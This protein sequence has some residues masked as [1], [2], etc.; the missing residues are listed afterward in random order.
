MLDEEKRISPGAGE[1][2]RAL[3]RAAAALPDPHSLEAALEATVSL[4]RDLG[5]ADVRLAHVYLWGDTT[6]ESDLRG[7]AP[8]PGL[9]AIL[10]AQPPS[11]PLPAPLLAEAAGR[12][13]PL[14]WAGDADVTLPGPWLLL[15]L[16]AGPAAGVLALSLAQPVSPTG[17]QAYE[18]LAR[19][20]GQA[21]ELAVLRRQANRGM[22]EVRLLDRISEVISSSLSLEEIL[23]QTLAQLRAV[24]PFDGGAIALRTAQDDLV[25]RATYGEVDE[26]ARRVRMP[27]GMGI[28]GWVAQHGRPY[29][30]NDLDDEPSVRPAMRR[31]GT[32]R[33]MGAYMAAPLR[34]EG[35][36]IGILQVNSS[37]K[38]VFSGRDLAL[39][40]EVADRCA[41]A[42]ERA[43]LFDE[44]QARADRLATVAQ[45]AR[46]ISAALDPQQL[47]ETCYA[48]VRKV[49][50]A[51]A[52][53]VALYDEPA[54]QVHYAFL[55]DAGEQFPPFS[56]PLG[57]GLTGYVIRTRQPL[58]VGDRHEL[59]ITPETFGPAARAA[60]S[61]LMVPLIFEGRVLGAMST[62][63]YGAHAYRPDDLSLLTTIANQAAV[64]IRNAQ[65]YQS[66]REAQRAKDE[67]LSMVSHE[68]RT[69]LTTI[70]GTAQVMQ[71][72]LRRAV[73]ARP[74]GDD[75]LAHDLRRL[76]MIVG[77]AERLNLLVD[78]LLDLSGL[79]S[80]R[81]E[82]APAPADLAEVVR[83][84]VEAARAA[85]PRHRLL[86]D[87]PGPVP[88]TFDRRRIEQVISNLI[89]NAVKYSPEGS[90]VRVRLQVP[91]PGVARVEVADQGPGLAPEDAAR[92]FERFYRGAAGRQ[93]TRAGL[94]LGLYI[95]RQIVEWHGGD[96]DVE[97]VPGQGSTFRFTLPLDRPA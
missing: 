50:P 29:L 78:D 36:V 62:Q 89:S 35:R 1:S 32:N 75:A 17:T 40:A 5:V 49:M 67:F 21:L 8:E 87:V 20:C 77:Q 81:F 24:I 71:R 53:L 51:E 33:R 93:N 52:F 96:I 41:V 47:F 46:R 63:S 12:A 59:P 13:A 82:Y 39:L 94:G 15:P 83:D 61:L 16:A 10:P 86:V 7:S 30:S 26:A 45:I 44:M 27:V 34:A 43:R 18:V 25:I 76:A 90:T 69:P 74:P 95:S 14:E 66:E 97:S 55:R 88:G 58:V 73:G 91:A 68:L 70:K 85:G 9:R 48:Q 64:A 3:T 38:H 4:A 65:L 72:R 84:A 42:V 19:L 28:S 79:Q 92:L 80:G 37:S 22:A 11:P 2:L 6:G 31:T 23:T 57:E 60:E 56:R 54:G